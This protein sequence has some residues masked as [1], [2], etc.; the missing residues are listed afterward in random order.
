MASNSVNH[1]SREYFK[2]R[3]MDRIATEFGRLGSHIDCG[4][5]IRHVDKCIDNWLST[6]TFLGDT[7]SDITVPDGTV[8][9]KIMHNNPKYMSNDSNQVMQNPDELTVH[10]VVDDEGDC[11]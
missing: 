5:L 3:T 2:C 6:D 11:T 8:R 1:S 10:F 7:L 4:N 9:E